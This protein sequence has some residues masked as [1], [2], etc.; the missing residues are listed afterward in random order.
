[1]TTLVQSRPLPSNAMRDWAKVLGSATVY[2]VP[3]VGGPFP[4]PLYYS[5]VFRGMVYGY[6]LLGQR[7]VYLVQHTKLNCRTCELG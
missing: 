1:V 6:G 4:L 5:V 2:N 7:M 3:Q